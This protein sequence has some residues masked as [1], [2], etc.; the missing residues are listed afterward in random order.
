VAVY[1]ALA[2][3]SVQQAFSPDRN[4]HE[5]PSDASFLFFMLII[6]SP[7]LTGV[8]AAGFGVGLIPIFAASGA[9]R[10]PFLLGCGIG[11]VWLALALRGVPY[12]LGI[13]APSGVFL[14]SLM[15]G[16]VAFVVGLL[17][18]TPLGK[19]GSSV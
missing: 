6:W 10:R 5:F 3:F 9:P 19:T 17:F 7:L 16:M 4:R 8:A 18:R 14:V 15:L 12:S 1:V 2:V 13:G 11:C